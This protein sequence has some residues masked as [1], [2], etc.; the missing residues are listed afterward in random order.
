MKLLLLR[1]ICCL[2]TAD[3]VPRLS[4]PTD[5]SKPWHDM[6]KLDSMLLAMMTVNLWG[7]IDSMYDVRMCE[8]APR[9]ILCPIAFQ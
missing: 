8:L 5:F 3:F 6:G 1:Y 9:T 7:I 4:V 2:K